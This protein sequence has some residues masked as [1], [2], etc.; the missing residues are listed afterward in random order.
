MNNVDILILLLIEMLSCVT[1]HSSPK[2]FTY[3]FWYQHCSYLF[4]IGADTLYLL[5]SLNT[6]KKIWTLAKMYASCQSHISSWADVETESDTE[7]L[8]DRLINPGE[9][10]P[11]VP[12]AEEH[13]AAD[14]QKTWGSQWRTHEK[15][16]SCIHLWWI[17][18]VLWLSTQAKSMSQHCE[19][20]CVSVIC[21]INIVV[22]S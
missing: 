17:W 22:I 16:D 2:Y 10:E 15:A 8:P 7:S 20:N 5:W 14:P 6:N 12:T 1:S 19:R 18:C 11:M 3:M 21:E 4:H 9:Y 13:T